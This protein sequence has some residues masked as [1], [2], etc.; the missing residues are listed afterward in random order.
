MAVRLEVI[1]YF[2]D[3]NRSLVYR[4]PPSPMPSHLFA[5]LS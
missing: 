5:K 4:I 2:D 1:Q 3:I